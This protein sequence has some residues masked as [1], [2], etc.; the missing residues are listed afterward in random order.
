MAPADRPIRIGVIGAADGT[1][2]QTRIA[3]EAGKLIAER[4]GILVCGGMSGV[5]EAACRG[6]S[7]A[8]GITVGILP[9]GS[10]AEGNDYVSIP[11]L[12]GMGYARNA[13][14]VRTSQ[15]VIAIGG[16]YGTLSEI[17]YAA[18]FGIPVIGLSTWKIRAP[19]RHVRTPQEAVT[20]AFKLALED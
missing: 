6:A 3:E 5:M 2:R 12:T 18:Q 1:A 13:L 19:I 16:R 7:L 4:G 11:V 14:V 10:A 20:L 15:A 9:G 8:G 17:A